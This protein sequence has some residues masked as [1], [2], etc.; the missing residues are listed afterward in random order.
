MFVV[1]IGATVDV[2]SRKLSGTNLDFEAP[3]MCFFDEQRRDREVTTKLKSPNFEIWKTSIFSSGHCQICRCQ[4]L[5][6]MKF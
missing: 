1:A 2:L 5:I 4:I 6:T 3:K